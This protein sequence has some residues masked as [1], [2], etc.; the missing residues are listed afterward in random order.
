MPSAK[1]PQREGPEKAQPQVRPRIVIK[2]RDEVNLPYHKG[3][4]RV[5]N[6]LGLAPWKNI[7]EAAPDA[8]L[9]PVFISV[10]EEA[11]VGIHAVAPIVTYGW[12]VIPVSVQ[13]GKTT[14]KTSL[15]PK[16]GGYLVPIKDAVR[17][18]EA[19]AEGDT[20]TVNIAIRG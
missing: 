7:V 4:E 5:L 16:D 10:P 13:I 20:A 19:L 8:T 3:A 9:E 2:F 1:K 11:C 15:F 12:G 6:E 17:K 18:A 14:W